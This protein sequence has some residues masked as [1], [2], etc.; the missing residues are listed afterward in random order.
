MGGLIPAGVRS[1]V[2]SVEGGVVAKHP[3]HDV[4]IV[5]IHNTKQARVLEGHDSRTITAEAALGA[6]RN[7]GLGPTDVDGVIGSI[8]SE[9]IYYLR[10]GPCYRSISQLGI[11]AVLEGAAAIATGMANTVLIAAGS[12]GIYTERTSTAPWTRPAN[13]FVVAYGMFTAAEFALIA[14]RHMHLY[15]TTPEQIATVAATI[16]NNG[17]VHPDAVYSGRGPF[18]PQDILDSRMVADPYHLL[19]CAMTSEGG[20]ALVMTRADIAKDLAGKPIY[21]L[22][23]N[24]DHFGPSYQHPPTFDLGGRRGADLVNGRAGR[25]AARD[26][27]GMSGLGPNDVDVCEFYDPF[28]LEIIRQ[29]ESFGFC[30]DGEGGEFIMNG[31]IGPGGRYPTTTDGGLMSFSHGGATVQ[32][33]QRVLRGVEQLRGECVTN[34]VPDAKV[35]MCSGGGS[36]ALFTDVMLLGS[37]RA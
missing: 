33:L 36:G 25:K 37:E 15:G 34:Q 26:S 6:L 24:S 19:D 27:F 35:A 17:H 16:R 18:T 7:A 8:A 10:I 5:G 32:L 11:P 2:S 30:E 20:C 9:L 3:F 28:S 1:S 21:I 14:R 12:A 22:G 23:G 29:F 13:E 31:T 4:A